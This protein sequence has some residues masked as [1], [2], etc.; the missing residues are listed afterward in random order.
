LVVFGLRALLNIPNWSDN[1]LSD[2]SPLPNGFGG[3]ILAMGL[4]FV[5]FEGYEII[6][7]SGEEVKSPDRNI[8]RAIFLAIVIVVVIYLAVAFVSIGALQQTSGLSNWL[9]LGENGER[10][11]IETARAIMPYGALLMILGGLASTMSALNATIYSSSRVSF[12]M[13]RDRDLPA[14]F[15]RIHSHNKT[16]HWIRTIKHHIGRFGLADY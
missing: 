15:G 8:P 2:P 16:P 1:F 13:G 9:Y 3:V 4:T 10:A 11:M 5:A 7:Q 6:A 14:V 12:A